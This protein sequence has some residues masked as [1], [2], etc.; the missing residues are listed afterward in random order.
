[1]AGA[2]SLSKEQRGNIIELNVTLHLPLVFPAVVSRLPRLQSYHCTSPRKVACSQ[3]DPSIAVGFFC[4]TQEELDQFC[5]FSV[6][7]A[8]ASPMY[9]VQP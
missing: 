6:E 8:G 5:S 1:M 4:S 7:D 9:S 2:L 3:I